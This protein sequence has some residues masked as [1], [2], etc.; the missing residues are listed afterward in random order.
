MKWHSRA[1]TSSCWAPA[2]STL[3]LLRRRA[4]EVRGGLCRE[5]RSI[6]IR[7]LA[8]NHKLEVQSLA[9]LLAAD[10]ISR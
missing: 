6:S 5:H 3:V 8:L 4:S 9:G 2:A 10:P 7:A 1:S